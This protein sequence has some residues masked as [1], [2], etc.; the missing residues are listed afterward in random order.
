MLSIIIPV[1]QEEECINSLVT[2]LKK[3]A[4][5]HPV[6]IVV[7]DGGSTDNT[8][9]RAREAG[10]QVV[11]SPHKGRATQMNFG[12]THAIYPL[13]YFVHADT[14]PPAG[15]IKDIFLSTHTGY[16]LGRYRTRF[17]S[18][19]LL[20]KLNAFFTRYDWSICYGGDQSLFIIKALF[21]KI[22]GFN[23][24]MLIMEEY[25]LVTRARKHG[26]YTI[27]NGSCLVSARKYDTNSWLTVQLANRKIMHMWRTGASQQEM[28]DQ[29]RRMLVYR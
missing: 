8:V 21:D 15:Y 26:R 13:L 12:A 14:T 5:E 1:Y 18:N 28:I 27:L 16:H 3:H 6:Q 10:A 7:S 19:S 2:Y 23:A 11:L 4:T 25:D 22:G 29:Y 9:K 20:L 24:N 17:D